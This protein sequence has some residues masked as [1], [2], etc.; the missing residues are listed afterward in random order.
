MGS[1]GGMQGG[2]PRPKGPAKS[3]VDLDG[4]LLDGSSGRLQACLPTC[5]PH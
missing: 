1:Q 4:C 2:T 5:L 3:Q